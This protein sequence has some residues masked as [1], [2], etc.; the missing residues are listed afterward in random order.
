ME[1]GFLTTGPPG[2]CPDLH[3]FKAHNSTSLAPPLSSL[4]WGGNWG[5]KRVSK[6]SGLLRSSWRSWGW[7]PGSLFPKSAGFTV[8]SAISQNNHPS[9]PSAL[10]QPVSVS[11]WRCQGLRYEQVSLEIGGKHHWNWVQ[12][13]FPFVVP[14][15]WEPPVFTY[16]WGSP[17]DPS[18]SCWG[19]P[20]VLSR[21]RSED[22]AFSL[23]W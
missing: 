10:D 5:T 21:W 12:P 2:K 17:L 15:W 18:I 23:C 13:Y 7:T 19:R 3:S 14:I 11:V 16:T 20:R 9:T 22:N 4:H 8:A 6:C 1:G